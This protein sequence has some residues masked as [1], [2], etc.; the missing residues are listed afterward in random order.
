ATGASDSSGAYSNSG[1]SSTHKRKAVMS[2]E[3]PE[4]MAGDVEYNTSNESEQDE[5]GSEQDEDESEQEQQDED[6]DDGKEVDDGY[7]EDDL[8]LLRPLNQELEW[9]ADKYNVL[10]LFWDLKNK[11]RNQKYSLSKDT[12]ADLSSTGEFAK[13]VKCWRGHW[14]MLLPLP[15][16]T[17]E[18]AVKNSEGLDYRDDLVRLTTVCIDP[19]KFYPA[20]SQLAAKERQ[21]FVDLVLP[22]LRQMFWHFGLS[23]V[24]RE[25]QVLG[26][27]RRLNANRV[28]LVEKV[29]SANFAD[30]AVTHNG[31]QPVLVECGPPNNSN[32]DKRFSD[33]YKLIRDLKDTW[34]YCVEAMIRSNC[35]PPTNMKVFGVQAFG[36]EVELYCLDFVGCFRLQQLTSFTVPSRGT[37]NLAETFKEM[38]L[39]C[40]GFAQMVAEE[41]RCW[42]GANRWQDEGERRV[43][44]KA[45]DYLPI[46]VP[47]PAKALKGKHRN[48]EELDE[49]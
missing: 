11:S 30:A 17:F 40:H 38:V 46:T 44:E 43:A 29:V 33:H 49:E 34:V 21:Y 25:T 31:L 22:C 5:D 3:E 14:G 7:E 8:A 24:I 13:R 6:D 48:L 28:P 12:I 27:A 35:I 23:M 16:S 19:M 47:R 32:H 18:E 10:T 39:C 26:C 45:L 2:D 9:Y 41:L 42:D 20:G 37:T 4:D 36:Q 1:A 15:T